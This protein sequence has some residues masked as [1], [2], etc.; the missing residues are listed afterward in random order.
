MLRRADEVIATDSED[1]L[2]RV[3]EI[4]GGCLKRL[5]AGTC[6]AC[7]LS[8]DRSP[9]GTFQ[10]LAAD[11]EHTHCSACTCICAMCTIAEPR[12][13]QE[14]SRGA[15]CGGMEGGLVAGHRNTQVD[16][17]EP[18]LLSRRRGGG[19]SAGLRWRR[20]H[21]GDDFGAAAG[22]N[23]GVLRLPFRRT[24]KASGELGACVQSWLW[25]VA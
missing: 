17:R 20:V 2:T 16:A 12:R 22:R 4:T 19:G 7:Y 14:C 18:P 5:A 11:P 3:R 1:L 8:D 10:S 24:C 15:G 21:R 9:A 23:R 6:H 13:R 25:L